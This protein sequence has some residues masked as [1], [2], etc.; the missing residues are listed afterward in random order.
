[1]TVLTR[2]PD[3][4][5]PLQPTKFLLTFDKIR[6]TQ[7]FCQTVNIPGISLGE[8]VRTTPFLDMYSP[9]TKLNY[10][11]L[12]IEFIVDSELNSWKNMY[13]WFI[14][15]ADPD[16]FEKRDHNT[17]APSTK[18]MTDAILTVMSSLNNP[19]AR[20]QYRNL[21]PTSLGQI[22][23]D[24]QLSAENIITCRAS[25]RYESYNYLTL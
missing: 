13:N 16:G 18:H 14:S 15:M 20:I 2:T 23:F 9:G 6:D 7:Y 24:T 19:V 8:V 5:N 4:T 11:P 21:F 17:A 3:N 10:E 22:Q 25:F 1:M 12:D